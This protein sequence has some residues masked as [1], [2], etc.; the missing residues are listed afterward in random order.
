MAE[1]NVNKKPRQISIRHRGRGA[2]VFIYLG[3]MLRM[4]I[5]QND[6]K[7]LPMAALIAGLVGMVVRKRFFINMEGTLM[8]AFA[9]VCV[10]IW[11]G[12]FNSIQVICRERDVI[13]REHRSGMHVSSYIFSHMLY[14]ALLCAAQTVITLAVAVPVGVQFP[15]TGLIT[16]HFLVEFG[17]SMFLITYASDML[18]LWVSTL[19]HNTTTAMTIMPFVLIFQLVFSGGMISLPA[20]TKPLTNFTISNP[21][22]KVIAAQSDTN[23]RPY[24][25]ISSMIGKMRDNEIGGT[26]TVG[27]VLDLLQKEDSEAISALRSK[28]I[29]R[30]YSLGEIKDM[31]EKS[32]TFSAFRQEHIL[33]DATMGDVLRLLMESE[34]FEETKNTAIGPSSVTIG[35]L[36]QSI[37][38]AE[39]FKPVAEKQLI[40]LTTVGDVLDAVNA[41]GLL[42]KYSDVQIGGTF[43]VGQAVDLLAGNPDVQARRD[44]EITVKT[45]VGSLLDM[46]GESKVKTFLEEKAAA[47]SY[48]ADYAY[49][50]ENVVAYWLHLAGFIVAF[51]L[52]AMITLEFIDKDKR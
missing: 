30:A 51:A 33:E 29:G 28:E 34:D 16:K 5:Y 42:E 6:W 3:K 35:N 38:D 47:A 20:W 40:H 14:Q 2:Q 15:Q 7:V 1:L 13:K 19:A 11:N 8:G 17:I 31:L 12:C 45:T 26:V 10:C 18:S 32:A 39:G 27:Q 36:I 49:T 23:N 4:F 44:Q 24:A 21:G 52:L 50:A 22:L 43:T 9:M 25:T 41:K 48:T 37:L 46:V